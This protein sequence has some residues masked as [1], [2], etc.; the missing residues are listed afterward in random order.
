M[1]TLLAKNNSVRK[2]TFFTCTL[3][4]SVYTYKYTI[5]I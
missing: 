5:N 2:E 1:L 4:T 3:Y